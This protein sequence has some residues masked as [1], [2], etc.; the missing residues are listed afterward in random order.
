MSLRGQTQTTAIGSRALKS[1]VEGPRLAPYVCHESK[2]N[3]TSG[4]K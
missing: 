3:R 1:V 2:I 4:R